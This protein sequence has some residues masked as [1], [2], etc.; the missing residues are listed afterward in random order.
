MIVR[1][2]PRA[3]E[4]FGIFRLSIV[5]KI[6]PQILGIAVF[7]LLIAGLGYRFPAALRTLNVAP[8][9]LLG[10]ALSIFLGFRNNV[11]YDRWWEARRQLGALIGDVRSFAR[12][13]MA[14]P[15]GDRSRRERMVRKVIA[16]VYALMAHLRSQPMPAE[17]LRYDPASER[18]AQTRNVP[19]ALLRELAGEL[20]AMLQA[21]EIGEITF[22][23]LDERLVAMSAI[24]VACER[25]KGT[26]TPFTY[27]LLLHR[28]AYAFCFMLPFGLVGTLGFATPIFCAVVAYAFF[29]LDELGS[30]LEEPFGDWINS[31]PLSAMARTVEIS[32]LE[33]LGET[34]LPEPPAPVNSV[35]T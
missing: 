5:P 22:A 30:E 26:P 9:T 1:S 16:Y 35:L 19:D 10:I 4:L 8:F 33:A 28:T 34:N 14:L 3:W 13:L 23:H 7:S 25:I 32:L 2:R 31:L 17:V 6:L 24:Q 20:A 27:T 11:S 21:G 18:I 12:L 29:G 15:G